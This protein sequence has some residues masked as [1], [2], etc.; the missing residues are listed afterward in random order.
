[1]A[2][3]RFYRSVFSGSPLFAA[4]L[5]TQVTVLNLDTLA[6]AS[7]FTDEAGTTP[8][9]NP[10]NI[11]EVGKFDFWVA[12]GNYRVTA[13]AGGDSDPWEGRIGPYSG[14]V[15]QVDSIVGGNGLF[16]DDSDAANPVATP[17]ARI[18][19]ASASYALNS[20]NENEIKVITG[21]GLVN[22]TIP[23]DSTIDLPVGFCHI[24]RPDST[25]SA[26]WVAESGAVSISAPASMSLV[27]GSQMCSAAIK[28]A[29]NI[30][31]IVG[32]C[33]AV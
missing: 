6:L 16:V 1:M 31:F 9:S 3:Y 2:N 28:V 24:I 4:G 17:R 11:S 20:T 7:I 18:Y 5:S 22:V 13:V 26:Q 10:F 23:E 33:E 25:A 27:C 30:W 19:T 12:A 15:G 29:S 32:R 8:K 14:D 21:G